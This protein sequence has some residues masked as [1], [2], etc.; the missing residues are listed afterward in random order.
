MIGR[1]I[2]VT[3][4]GV[5]SFLVRVIVGSEWFDSYCR[6]DNRMDARLYKRLQEGDRRAIDVLE[7]VLSPDWPYAIQRSRAMYWFFRF[8][9]IEADGVEWPQPEAADCVAWLRRNR[10]R[11]YVD[12]ERGR[13][14][15]RREA[16]GEQ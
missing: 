7:E 13:I 14:V 4:V 11:L 15:L 8:V 10:D 5:V 1:W 6:G 9:E 12:G 3:A 2:G 16:G